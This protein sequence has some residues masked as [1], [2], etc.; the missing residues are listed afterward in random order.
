MFQSKGEDLHFLMKLLS[1]HHTAER[2]EGIGMKT[3]FSITKDNYENKG[4]S[5]R[6]LVR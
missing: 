6:N 2:V 4:E 1:C 5:K 3:Q